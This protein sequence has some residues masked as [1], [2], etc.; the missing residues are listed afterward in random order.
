ME[1]IKLKSVIFIFI[2]YSLMFS[3][4]WYSNINKIEYNTVEETVDI[5]T[6]EQL[7]SFS[8]EYLIKSGRKYFTKTI[9]V[10][11]TY[12]TYIPGYYKKVIIKE[13]GKGILK[14]IPE[15]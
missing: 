7:K 13:K 9:T 1:S 11:K 5:K 3:I 6:P 8:N 2:L 12:K 4:S 10:Y 14:Y 15:L